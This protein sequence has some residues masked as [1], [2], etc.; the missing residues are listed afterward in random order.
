LTKER[1]KY[2]DMLSLRAMLKSLDTC[3]IYHPFANF[4]L[5]LPQTLAECSHGGGRMPKTALIKQKSCRRLSRGKGKLNSLAKKHRH[6][7]N[8]SRGFHCGGHPWPACSTSFVL[9]YFDL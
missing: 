2:K 5:L 3:L 7:V 8:N 1:E 6:R 9:T 4:L